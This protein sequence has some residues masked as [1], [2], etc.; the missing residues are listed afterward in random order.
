MNVK[1]TEQ[2]QEYNVS[3]S[4]ALNFVKLADLVDVSKF[5]DGDQQY[6]LSFTDKEV[7]KGSVNKETVATHEQIV[8]G[9]EL[10]EIQKNLSLFSYDKNLRGGTGW[11][12]PKTDFIFLLTEGGLSYYKEHGPE[13][14]F[15]DRGDARTF[16][17]FVSANLLKDYQKEGSVFVQ[18]LTHSSGLDY[19]ADQQGNLYLR[20]MY[21]SYIEGN[22]DNGTYLLNEFAEHLLSHHDVA[23]FKDSRRQERVYSRTKPSEKELSGIVKSIPYYNEEPGRDE[24]IEFIYYPSNEAI[25]KILASDCKDAYWHLRKFVVDEV[26]GGKQFLVKPPEEEKTNEVRRKFR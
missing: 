14:Q 12:E 20:P 13:N 9:T 19:L 5:K 23:F 16:H 3:H 18:K 4:F 26:L 10:A 8:L 21:F 7:I 2:V 15:T 1:T 6:I 25:T 17:S 22:V 24:F 11:P